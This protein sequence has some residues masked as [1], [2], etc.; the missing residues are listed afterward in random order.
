MKS[1][2]LYTDQQ[3]KLHDANCRL[4]ELKFKFTP[5]VNREAKPRANTRPGA[6]EQ[7]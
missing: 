1:C 4:Q 2:T 5:R 3:D 6:L 7:R